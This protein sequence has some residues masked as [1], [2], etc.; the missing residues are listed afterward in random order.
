MRVDAEDVRY[1]YVLAEAG[2]LSRAA[3]DLGVNHTTVSRRLTRLEKSLGKRLFSRGA[4]GWRLT[5]EG[6]SVLAAAR[7]V[8]T[9]TDA[10]AE[11]DPA[12]R[13]REE[14]RILAPDGFAQNV[15]APRCARLMEESGVVLTILT[16]ASLSGWEHGAFD[17]AVVR[18]RPTSPRVTSHLLGYYEVGLYAA[19]SYLSQHPPITGLG[20]LEDHPFIWYPEEVVAAIPEIAALRPLLPAV[21]RIQSNN[22]VVHQAAVTS[23]AGLGIMP[24]YVADREPT[25]ERVLP[26]ELAY[27]GQ[28]W[29][30]LPSGGLRSNGAREVVAFLQDAVRD[31]G[32]ASGRRPGK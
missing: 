8:A 11:N 10:V 12:A 25:L 28:Y 32:I 24:T 6:E 4:S 19:Q 9:G 3:Q 1:F 23:G 31:F 15:L 2:T 26:D 16:S 22:L 14:W 27:T 13:T 29:T 18:H 7:M 21:F 5:P 17:A 30:V 20:D